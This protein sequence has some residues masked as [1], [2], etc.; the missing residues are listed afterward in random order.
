M[1]PIEPTRELIA[2]LQA[3]EDELGAWDEFFTRY[4]DGIWQ[5]CRSGDQDDATAEDL[6]QIVSLALLR[7]IHTFDPRRHFEPWVEGVIR[8]VRHNHLGAQNLAN[9]LVVDGGED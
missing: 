8:N 3:G 7:A 5:R 9:R 1:E 4:R 2:R 6:T